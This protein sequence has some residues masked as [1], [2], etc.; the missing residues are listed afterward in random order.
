MS[1]IDKYRDFN[2]D[3]FISKQN[4]RKLIPMVFRLRRKG[5]TFDFISSASRS[6]WTRLESAIEFLSGLP[7]DL[8]YGVELVVYR[9]E[10]VD[11]IRPEDIDL[12][13]VVPSKKGFTVNYTKFK[14]NQAK[15]EEQALKDASN[16]PTGN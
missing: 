7:N 3:E 10:E 15:R 4:K 8:K 16:K 9:L 12:D 1:H 14:H 2:L 13:N 6:H 11:I 5:S